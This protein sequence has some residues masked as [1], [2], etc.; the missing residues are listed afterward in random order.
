MILPLSN[1]NRQML[2]SILGA[3]LLLM[4]LVLASLDVEYKVEPPP[5]IT[6]REVR[7][8]T[9]PPP[10]PPPMEQNAPGSAMPSLTRAYAEDPVRLDF[11]ELEVDMDVNI[12][13][14]AVS[15][16]GTGGPGGGGGRGLGMGGGGEW[17]TVSLSELD[18]IPMVQS[19]GIM[20]YPEEA[21]DQNI[22]KFEVLLHIIIDEMGRT[23]PVRIMQNP[24]PSMNEEIM[25]YASAV[26]FTPPTRQGAPVRTEYA[27]P[28]LIK[29]PITD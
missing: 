24:F 14:V 3:S 2:A 15:G 22:L 18:N 20:S 28:L 11:M 19:A 27:W 21:I 26:V 10:P 29:K 5:K 13:A 25:K 6:M 4:L 9:P 8:Y 12:E 1:R 7:M 16:F 17:G 23:Y